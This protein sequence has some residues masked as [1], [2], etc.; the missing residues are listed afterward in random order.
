MERSCVTKERGFIPTQI[1]I[2]SPEISYSVFPLSFLFSFL[3]AISSLPSAY[4]SPAEPSYSEPSHR[5]LSFAF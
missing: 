1:V 4:L 5:S 2:H 3:S